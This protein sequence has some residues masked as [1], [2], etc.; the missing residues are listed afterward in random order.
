MCRKPAGLA[1][2]PSKSATLNAAAR[3]KLFSSSLQ[4][5]LNC[6]R[7]EPGRTRSQAE[8]ADINFTALLIRIDSRDCGQQAGQAVGLASCENPLLRPLGETEES[9]IQM[10]SAR[11]PLIEAESDRESCV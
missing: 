4:L 1:L 11:T 6:T 9:L 5:N 8:S 3:R 7:T 10:I 2:L